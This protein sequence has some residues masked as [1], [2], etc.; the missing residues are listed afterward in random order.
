MEYHAVCRQK[1]RTVNYM[2]DYTTVNK[3]NKKV[4]RE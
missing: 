3:E 4:C 2:I 1:E